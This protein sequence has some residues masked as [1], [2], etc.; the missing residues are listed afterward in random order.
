M[1]IP[2]S[3]PFD[4]ALFCKNVIS[5]NEVYPLKIPLNY[6]TSET[7]QFS[8]PYWFAKLLHFLNIN[9]RDSALEKYQFFNVINAAKEEHL[10]NFQR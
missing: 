4:G 1:K 3:S 2:N 10:L 6:S 9:A 8:N 5:F 7:F